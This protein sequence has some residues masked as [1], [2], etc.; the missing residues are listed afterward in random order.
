[1]L[2]N[3]LILLILPILLCSCTK[4]TNETISFASWGSI[5]ETAIIK[6]VINDFEKENPNIKINFIHVPQN[7]FQKMHLMFASNTPPDVLFLNNLYLPIYANYLEDLSQY[8]NKEDFFPQ[9]LDGLSYDG[10]LLGVPR[11]VSNLV[12]YINLDKTTLPN[13][14][15]SLQDLINRCQNSKTETT[16]CISHED[17]IYWALPYLSY[18]GGGILDRNLNPIIDSEN[19][20]TALNFYRDLVSKYHY[21]PAKSEVGSSTLAQM[22]ME[23]KIIFYLSGRWMYPKISEKADFNWAVINFPYGESPQLLD[24]SGWAVAKASKH[25]EAAIKFVQFISSEQTSKYF[26]DTGLIIP[27]RKSSA[28]ALNNNKHNEKVFLEVIEKSENTPVSKDYNK[29]TDKLNKKLDL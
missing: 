18:F 5:T 21:A 13:K 28:K 11:D 8:I 6:E 29:L 19:S 9:T 26:T 25:K 16:F 23:G 20:I 2:K 27:A 24:T 10:K 3:I 12:L 7:Y 22:F 1:M 17:S 4:N 15:W 14:N